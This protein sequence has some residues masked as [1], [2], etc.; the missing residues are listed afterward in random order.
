MTKT[1][2]PLWN[3]EELKILRSFKSPE[4]IQAFL[5][6]V[7]YNP[8]DTCIS[9]RCVMRERKAHCME[10]ALFAAAALEFIG[11]KPIMVY[12]MAVRDDGHALAIYKR[13]GKYGCLAKSNVSVLRYRSPVYRTLRELV[14]SYF[15]YYFNIILYEIIIYLEIFTYLFER[16]F[17]QIIVSMYRYCG[18]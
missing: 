13:N 16:S 18:N 7:P 4:S 3:K 15:D 1:N 6:N 9:P 14:I 8:A 17:W 11:Y 5:D 10:G 12:I 2:N